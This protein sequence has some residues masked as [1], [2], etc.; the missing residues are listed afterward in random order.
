MKTTILTLTAIAIFGSS[1]ASNAG[2][3]KQQLGQMLLGKNSVLMTQDY[4]NYLP[5]QQ[6]DAGRVGGYHPG[7]DYRARQATNI[8]APLNGVVERAGGSVGTLAIKKDGSDTR[9]ILL[10]MSQFFVKPGDKVQT[11]CLIGMSGKTGSRGLH[12]ERTEP[13]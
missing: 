5:G 12:G 11:G 7:I 10:H 6:N 3:T 9:I 4:L 13:S 1:S 8:Y 2:V